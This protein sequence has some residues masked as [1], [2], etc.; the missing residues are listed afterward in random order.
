[1][2][3]GFARFFPPQRNKPL[4]LNFPSVLKY[5]MLSIDSPFF[6]FP[7]IFIKVNS[8]QSFYSKFKIKFAFD[9]KERRYLRAVLFT[10]AS[11]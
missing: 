5:S 4:I 11:C 9:F 7:H 6:L 10:Q 3:R 1:M 2:D 8:F